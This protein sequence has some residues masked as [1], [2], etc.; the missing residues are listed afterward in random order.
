MAL[1]SPKPLD[2]AFEVELPCGPYPGLR[3]FNKDE[4]PIFFGRE[5]MT[6]EVIARVIRQHLVVVH[7]DSGCGKS[8]LVRAGVLAQL[9]Q[10]RARSGVRWRTATALPREAPL[11]RLAEAIAELQGAADDPD[12]V[13]QVRRIL[14][15]GADAP[16]ALAELLRRGD[17]DHVCILIDQFEELFSLVPAH[18]REEAELFTAILVGLQKNPPPGLY[19]ILTMRS[20][21]L[22]HC[23]RFTGLAEAVNQTQYLLPQMERPALIRAIREPAVLYDGEVSRELAERLIADAGGGQDQLPLIQHGLMLLWRHKI[24]GSSGAKGFAEASWPY[25]PESG[26]EDGAPQS[27]SHERGPT[28]RLGL[29]DYRA[30]SLATLLSDHA[31]QVMAK[32]APDPHRKKI[33]EHLFRALTDINAEGQAIRRPQ[34]LAEL[35]A[36]TGTDEGTLT[37]IIGHFRAE[38]VSFLRPYGNARIEPDNEIDISHE[39]LIRCWQKI[40]PKEEDKEQGCGTRRAARSS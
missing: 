13:H 17:D 33:V 22:G 14:N 30:T 29:D 4:W 37:D 19:A 36:V 5:Q 34:T 38:G 21:F 6:D 9:E 7:G 10:E 1:P 3:P 32:A 25:R 31:N 16:A 35:M 12:R 15:R 24:G 26:L 28:W 8:S 23:A 40:L 20:E 39:A 18:G 2:A 11:R 27:F